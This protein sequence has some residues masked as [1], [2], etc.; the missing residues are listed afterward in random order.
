MLPPP[1]NPPTTAQQRALEGLAR[2]LLTSE[3][4]SRLPTVS[5][6]RE[7]LEVGTGTI[8]KAF[9]ELQANGWVEVDAKQKQGTSVVRRDLG[10]LWTAAGLAPLTVLLPLPNSWEFQGLASGLRAEFD[11][12]G[13]ATTFLYGHGAAERINAL[14]T[15]LAQ[16]VVASQSAARE[17]APPRVDVIDLG[18]GTYYAEGSMIVLARAP[19][20]AL[21][22]SLRIG[23]DR[24]SYDHSL[25]TFAE[26]PEANLVD[27]NYAHIPSAISRGTIDAA[28]WHRTALGLS[29]ADQG[30][31]PW[32]LQNSTAAVER[33]MCSA[34]L[35]IG[36]QLAHVNSVVGRIDLGRLHEMQSSVVA[37][38]VLPLY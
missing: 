10:A 17:L 9:L 25:L 38:D 34:A 36:P 8:Q 29:L 26:F 30:L 20:A 32:E 28:V 31:V 14:T 33:T 11:R 35:V 23:I 3:E 4:G 12:T 19:R 13:I 37:G 2:V 5:S 27:T 22:A 21:P 18:P 16:I 7:Q 24:D 15:G 1:A 6:L